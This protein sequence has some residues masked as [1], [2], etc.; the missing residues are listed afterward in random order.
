MNPYRPLNGGPFG[1]WI[2]VALL[3]SASAMIAARTT[4]AQGDVT[5]TIIGIERAALDRWGKGDPSGFF[6]IMAP[7]QTYFD[8]MTDKRID[9]H[10]ALTAYIAPF[11]GKISIERVEMIDPKVHR[12][13]DVAV[14]TFNLNDYGAQLAGGPKGTARWNATEVYQRIN[15]SWKIVHSHWSFVKPELIEAPEAQET[16]AQAIRQLE[17]EW[18]MAWSTRDVDRIVGHYA[19]D[20]SVELADVPIMSGKTAIRA[21]IMQAVSDENFALAFEPT[22]VEVSKGGDL[23][24][25]RGS[26][27]VTLTDVATKHAVTANGKYVIVY[28][29]ERDGRWRATHDINNRDAPAMSSK[30]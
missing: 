13:G 17:A 8:P 19:D 23:A 16:D 26:Y 25:S 14:L 1:P 29:K 4:S 20:A 5:E 2:L 10:E 6:E 3:L 24:Y 28:R 30:P 15:G 27:R 18:A 7:H 11:A 21:G 12:V 9:G 22:Q